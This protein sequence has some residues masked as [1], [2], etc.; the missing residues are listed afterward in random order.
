MTLTPTNGLHRPANLLPGELRS[1]ALRSLT[2]ERIEEEL[3]A[4]LFAA[5]SPQLYDP[6]VWLTVKAAGWRVFVCKPTRPVAHAIWTLRAEDDNAVITPGALLAV[7]AQLDPMFLER[8]DL[9]GSEAHIANAPL[10]VGTLVD[11]AIA[12]QAFDLGWEFLGSVLCEPSAVRSH[13]QGHAASLQEKVLRTGSGA[14]RDGSVQAISAERKAR[15]DDHGGVVETRIATGLDAF[16]STDSFGGLI[17][18]SGERMLIQGESKGRKTSLVLFMILSMARRGWKVA[19][20]CTDDDRNALYNWLLALLATAWLRVRLCDACAQMMEPVKSTLTRDRWRCPN[21]DGD[22]WHHRA[23]PEDWVMRPRLISAPWHKQVHR[24]AIAAAEYQLGQ[25]PIVLRDVGDGIANVDRL[26]EVSN[27][28]IDNGAQVLV[29]DYLQD[30]TLPGINGLD[31]QKVM[32]YL[33][34]SLKHQAVQRHVIHFWLSQRTE[35][36]NKSK[37]AS[38]GSGAKFAAVAVEGA[39]FIIHT[40][41]DRLKTPDRIEAYVERA[42]GAPSVTFAW[43]IEPN[44]ALILSPKEIRKIE[45]VEG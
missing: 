38:G 9:L 11:Q 17:L 40:H 3:L 32:D 35:E 29:F 14:V 27:A 2:T 36:Y 8:L 31:R 10:L 6:D 21:C 45:K 42:R 22:H 34:R 41:Y 24:D 28:D 16:D 26:L 39:N 43:D 30:F 5:S 25:L 12:R 7:S 20:N 37:G 4:A 19:I 15:A 23:P 44:S 33:V 1:E 18:E 13:V